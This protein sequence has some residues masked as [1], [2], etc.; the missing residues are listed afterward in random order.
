MK[1]I[2]LLSLLCI[3]EAAVLADV[4]KGKIPNGLTATG[5]ACA[6]AYQLADHGGAG[7]LLWMGGTALPVVLFFGFYYFRMIGAGDVKLMC[8]LGAFLGP[9]DCL[10]CITATIL[11]GAV[12]SLMIMLRC[13]NLGR[14]LACFAEYIST[15]SRELKWR[16]Y[17]EQT[18]QEARFCFSVPVLLGTIFYIAGGLI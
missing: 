5:L 1:E 18:P 4:W 17:L 6:L 11:S 7:I 3:A 8:V 10:Y 15:Y 16:P 14:R 9:T 2:Q 13:R 12:L